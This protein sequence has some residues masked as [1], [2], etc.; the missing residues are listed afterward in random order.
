M[1]T[2]GFIVILAV[3]AMVA[4]DALA[5][6]AFPGAEGFGCQATG[7]RGGS[8]YKVTNLN[9]TGAGSFRNGVKSS[10]TTVIFST[11]GTVTLDTRCNSSA[12]NMTL[13]GQTAPGGGFCVRNGDMWF[14]NSSNLVIRYTRFRLG[15]YAGTDSTGNYFDT[16]TLKNTAGAIVDHCSASWS[17]DECLSV[18][19]PSNNVTVQW[20]LIS[21][22]CNWNGHG[23]GSLISSD[24][25]NGQQSWHHNIW[26]HQAGRNPRA[27][28]RNNQTFLCDIVNNVIYDWGHTS[29][30]FGVWAGYYSGEKINL[31]WVNN[32]SIAGLDSTGKTTVVLS[33]GV[34]TSNIYIGSGNLIDSD[35]DTTRDGTTV[36]WSNLAGTYTKKTSAYTIPAWAAVT[37]DTSATAYTNIMSGVGATKPSRDSVD[38]RVLN[39]VTNMTGHNINGESDVGGWPTLA[40]G[41]APTDTDGDGMPDAWETANG[42]NPNVA[43]NNGDIDSDGYTN[44]EEYLNSL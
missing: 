3:L 2:L 18:T 15:R 42:T 40:A 37:T 20:C 17:G 38:T 25:V 34:S 26:A 12:V 27:A 32:Y 21:E 16:F 24:A 29:G 39:D 4:S 6:V 41:S 1:K 35:R 28:S 19:D 43:D 10:N 36:T 22:G 33:S 7:G 31:N 44:L 8:V 13:A 14:S 9:N 11:G 30:D 5:I 23:Y